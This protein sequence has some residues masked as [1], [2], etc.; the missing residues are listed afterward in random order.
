MKRL[1]VLLL[2]AVMLG[3]TLFVG[4]SSAAAST[5]A[6]NAVAGRYNLLYNWGTGYDAISMTL[7]KNHTGTDLFSDDI[8]WSLSGKTITLVFTNSSLP[9]ASATYIGTKNRQGISKQSKPGT[10]SNN[11]GKTGVWYAV[12][13]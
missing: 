10:M 5:A 11:S 6:P 7:L 8:A 12:K 1:S 3:S 13:S 4:A 9:G 2:S